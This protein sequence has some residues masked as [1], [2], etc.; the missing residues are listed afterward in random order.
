MTSITQIAFHAKIIMCL[1]GSESLK[2]MVAAVAA[3]AR[4]GTGVV[5]AVVVVTGR[6]G[7]R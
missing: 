4:K 1:G 7:R 2:A 3:A 6:G 5:M